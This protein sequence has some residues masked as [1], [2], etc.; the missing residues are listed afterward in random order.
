MAT[1][2]EKKPFGSTKTGESVTLF[3]LTANDS[4][5]LEV[6]DYGATIRSLKVRDWDGELTDVVLGYDTLKEYEENDGYFGAVVGRHANR[7]ENGTFELN[8]HIYQLARNDKGNHLHGGLRGFNCYVWNHTLLEDGIRFSRISPDGEEG[9]PGRLAVA[10][11]YLLKETGLEIIYDAKSDKDTIC[12][13]TNHSYFNLNGTGDVLQH[14][15]QIEADA[16][17]EN[18]GAC[19]P[20]GRILSAAGT[21]FDFRTAKLI[22]KDIGA[23]DKQLHNC[24]GYDHNFVLRKA[25]G[26]HLAAVLHGDESG[27]TMRLFTTMPGIQVYSANFLTKRFGKGGAVYHE[28]SGICLETQYFPN[29]M[30]CPG[31]EKPILRANVPYHHETYLAF[32]TK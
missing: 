30:A 13:L 3:S 18:S 11:T 7:I 8:H 16:F 1:K 29:A 2:I 28:R 17:T 25:V 32:S 19:L 23:K 22:G 31:F 6:L 20:T 27:I 4:L 21:P 26:L 10:V 15:L 9:Y 5:R 14:T 12:N 24:G